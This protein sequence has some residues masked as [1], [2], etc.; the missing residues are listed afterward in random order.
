MEILAI[1]QQWLT[2]AAFH[3]IEVWTERHYENN[4]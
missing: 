2:L 3:I 4:L 1:K